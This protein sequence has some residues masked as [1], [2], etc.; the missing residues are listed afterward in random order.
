MK[1]MSE[2]EPAYG[3]GLGQPEEQ[4]RS[5]WPP[6]GKTRMAQTVS[7]TGRKGTQQNLSTWTLNSLSPVPICS[8]QG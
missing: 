3:E 2:E 4:L 8:D 6:Q 5:Q 1:K 7:R